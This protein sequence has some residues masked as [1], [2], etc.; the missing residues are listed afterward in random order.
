MV[1]NDQLSFFYVLVSITARLAH[2]LL[3][4]TFHVADPYMNNTD[5]GS[6][7]TIY[8][9][10]E[11]G[12]SS[13]NSLIFDQ[14]CRREDTRIYLRL[15]T[16]DVQK[17]HDDS[18]RDLRQNM[19]ALVEVCWG[20]VV[21]R[22]VEQQVH[23]VR[24]PLWGKCKNVKLYLEL[25]NG[26]E[27]KRFIFWVHHPQCFFRPRLATIANGVSNRAI[28]AR[29]Q[30][31]ALVLATGLAEL[32]IKGNFYSQFPRNKYPRL[33]PGQ[34]DV[35]ER[36]MESAKHELRAAYPIRAK[37]EEERWSLLE[38]NRKEKSQQIQTI[39]QDLEKAT[40][41][42]PLEN[43]SGNDDLELW[44]LWKRKFKHLAESYIA[45]GQGISHHD[46][47]TILT[48]Q[49]LGDLEISAVEDSDWFDLPTELIDWLQGQD[50]LKIDGNPIDNRE[51]LETAFNL[52]R[53]SKEILQPRCIRT[54]TTEELTNS[55]AL[56]YIDFVSRRRRDIILELTIP[57]ISGEVIQRKCSS[58][59]RRVLDDAFPQF[60][61]KTRVLYVVGTL[62]DK[63][64]GLPGCK[65]RTD[66]IPV[67]QWQ[68][69]VRAI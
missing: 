22:R 31:T 15:R 60:A 42:S 48:S 8:L 11:N 50:G 24:F 58:C 23:L 59:G 12:F 26:G 30:D 56:A 13:E 38:S 19:H 57:R 18:V 47:G 1:L 21:W 49:T 67:D 37:E 65:G 28:Q 25:G 4:P 27:L 16:S 55:V 52:L 10:D 3:N 33:T 64:C 51:G 62:E 39:L 69:H 36:L 34:R 5:D 32:P 29:I 46:N 66:L 68:L 35:R 2:H 43:D 45:F 6:S 40:P 17:P 63:G 9:L 44:T 54:S 14:V 20:E 41:A 53:C 61:K 7:P